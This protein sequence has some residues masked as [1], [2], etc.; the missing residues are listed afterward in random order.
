MTFRALNEHMK[1]AY[2]WEYESIKMIK[3][4][5]QSENSYYWNISLHRKSTPAQPLAT[6]LKAFYFNNFL[7]TLWTFG[8]VISDLLADNLF[9]D[10]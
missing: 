8:T 1:T 9:Y 6:Y 2:D 4:S 7:T 3:V 5:S 10:S